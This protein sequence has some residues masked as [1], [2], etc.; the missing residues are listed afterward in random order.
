MQNVEKRA[1][2]WKDAGKLV[3]LLRI[4]IRSPLKDSISLL[5]FIPLIALCLTTFLASSRLVA[6][7]AS[8]LDRYAIMNIGL[9]HDLR[10][11]GV[12]NIVE[13]EEGVMWISSRKGVTRYNGQQTR[14]YTLPLVSHKGLISRT[15][16]ICRSASGL[17][18]AADERGRIYT[19]NPVQDRFD[20]RV[21]LMDELQEDV[22]LEGIYADDQEHLWMATNRGLATLSP[23]DSV[24]WLL[25]DQS[26]SHVGPVGDQLI[27]GSDKGIY[28]LSRQ[29]EPQLLPISDI[30]LQSSF[31]DA[32]TGLLWL[33]TFHQG[34]KLLRASDMT[35]LT[36]LALRDV[37]NTPV[38]V[39]TPLD[40][41][42]LIVGNDGT[43]I[44]AVSRDGQEVKPMFAADINGNSPLGGLGIYDVHVDSE[45]NLWIASYM[46]G[47][48]IA[49]PTEHL[50]ETIRHI[51]NLQNSLLCDVVNDVLESP[52]GALYFATEEGVSIYQPATGTWRHTLRNTAV[53]DLVC[54]P[55]G[56]VMAGTYGKG[57][58][59]IKEDGT[60]RQ[61]YSVAN[62]ALVSDYVYNLYA[63][64]D[65]SLWAGCLDGELAH[66]R[67]GQSKFYPIE[68]VQ[69]IT[70]DNDGNLIIGSGQGWYLLNKATEEIEHY[71][72]AQT[73]QD[74][75]LNISTLLCDS[76]SDVWLGSD[77]GGV[78]V[79]H[80]ADRWTE[81]ISTEH[82]LPSNVI[83]SLTDDGKGHV[84]VST[85]QGL[86]VIDIETHQVSNPNALPELNRIYMP[87]SVCHLRDGRFAFGSTTGTVIVD[88]NL[89]A[90]KP[91][92]AT[93][94]ITRLTTNG[95]DQAQ[96]EE[97][98]QRTY[99][100]LLDGQV[101][102]EAT[103]NSFTIHFESVCYAN[104]HDIQY[105]YL[106]EGFDDDWS[107]ISERQEAQYSR[108][109][110]GKY[111]LHI[112]CVSRN[113]G[114]EID[115]L[116]LPIT[117]AEPWWNTWWAW[118]CY[119]LLLAV[120]VLATINL[121]IEKQHRKDIN[122]RISFF[123]HIAHDLRTPLSLIQ[124]PLEHLEQ[125]PTLSPQAQQ[126]I[127]TIRTGSQQL[128]TLAKQVLNF[129]RV[130]QNHEP[131]LEPQNLQQ[132][133]TAQVQ[134]LESLAERKQIA[135]SLEAIP[136]ALAILADRTMV[137]SILENLLTNALKYTPAGG[138]VQVSVEATTHKVSIHIADTGI[139]IP[140]SEQ[141]RIF[142]H[143]YRASNAVSSRQDGTGL[144]LSY[145]HN[146]ARMQGGELSFISSEGNGST[147][148]LTM[149]RSEDLAVASV[150]MAD[151]S[152]TEPQLQP[153]RD[154]LL[155]VDDN[156]GL[157]QYI[158]IAFRDIYNV[159]TCTCAEEVLEYLRHDTCDILISDVMMPGMHGDELCR[160]LKENPDWS[161]LPVV[162]LTA[163]DDRESMLSGI[164]AGADDYVLKPFDDTLL[165][166]KVEALLA[167]RRRLNRY[168]L[169]HTIQMATNNQ[170][171]SK[172]DTETSTAEAPSTTTSDE[173]NAPQAM[174]EVD[175][176]FIE[177][178]TQL[179]LHN[180]SDGD[181][182]V[183]DLCRDMGMSRT[184]F[185]GRLKALT[186][187][188]PQQ[189]IRVIRMEHAASLLRQGCSIAEVSLDT[190]FANPKYFSTVFKSY[191]GISPGKYS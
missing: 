18:F 75:V 80:M 81:Q 51:D 118:M 178:A 112:R 156:E 169:D 5:R 42:T 4:N 116:T 159:V 133:L 25:S 45:E 92:D 44:Y 175:K 59:E 145:S 21:S 11:P 6:C 115:A 50:T 164:S 150:T 84:I 168:Y 166:H 124:A 41:N 36:P 79:R 176:K 121:I 160:Q 184:S 65:G 102:L 130:R 188:S 61:I 54:L 93:L 14:T 161:W 31:Y 142:S 100:M 68:I 149:K 174:T 90:V 158:T 8:N 167:N 16:R 94:R 76:H 32:S 70:A 138:S 155:F 157:R 180:L 57:I 27:V 37:P 2:I 148:T 1:K 96:E 110:S 187:Q 97:W 144:G 22:S 26:I 86:A 109:P 179:V 181:Y 91:Y 99:Q 171:E 63:E 189:F 28:T 129:N 29:G 141:K 3:Y 38:R 113:D 15:V 105:Q 33:G 126:Y 9:D 191:F 20:H 135:L 83:Y 182:N 53:L 62:G 137:D 143:Y 131:K 146:L 77:G 64:A 89:L 117:I 10:L 88:P 183:D 172:P 82:G 185:F 78:Y 49:F 153:D 67:E 47:I 60:S 17:L 134:K 46:G 40:D 30:N 190:G 104:Q 119:L 147:F 71:L 85:D 163:N 132:M 154:T 152:T 127:G 128:Q 122:R 12:H 35:E 87:R 111:Q 186:A 52:N 177:R 139:G 106:L 13:D 23:T 66:I 136:E 101:L 19:Y 73:H 140:K 108:V 120:I 55:Q 162:L 7:P 170:E 165:R 125:D 74:Y 58:F 107:D 48:D 34:A 56:Q 43:G 39:I 69:H 123:V 95:L 173:E 98:N 114:H 72:P 24:S 151:S 103:E